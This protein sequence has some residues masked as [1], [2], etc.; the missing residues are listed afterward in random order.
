VRR[1]SDPLSLMMMM[2]MMMMIV[3]FQS[4]PIQGLFRGYRDVFTIES[5]LVVFFQELFF[6]PYLIHGKTIE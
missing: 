4:S 5:E 3:M 1:V 2:M 6:L